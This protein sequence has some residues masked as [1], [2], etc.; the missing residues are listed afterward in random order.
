MHTSNLTGPSFARVARGVLAA[1]VLAV[2]LA[3]CAGD[4]ADGSR[5]EGTAPT[6][7]AATPA[8]PL[9]RYAGYTSSTHDD[10]THWVCRPEANDVCQGNLDTTVVKADGTMTVEPFRAAADPPVDCFYLYPT[11]SRDQTF[12]SDW[13]ASPDEEGWV[14]LN[15][16][17]RLRATC[18]LYAPIY[19]QMTL[20]GL[21]SRLGGA[22]STVPGPG[23]KVDPYADVLDAFRTYMAKDNR[24]RPFVL[25]GHSQGSSTLQRLVAEEIDPNPDVRELMLAAFLAGWPLGVPR[26]ADVGGAFKNIPLCR[27]PG[28]T[29]CVFA[30]SSYRSTAKPPADAYFGK[31]KGGGGVAAVGGGDVAA[32]NTPATLRDSEPADLHSYFPANRMESILAAPS[33]PGPPGPWVDP[34]KGAVTTPFVSVPG[35]V[36]GTCTTTDGFHYLSV[37]TRAVKADPRADDFGGELTPQWG[38]H[39]QD[40]NLV[41]GDVV[42]WVTGLAAHVGTR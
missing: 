9:A 8:G 14:T 39:L 42:E 23:E 24:G 10:P 20:S 40:V 16:A 26:G 31:V 28:Q 32:C 35:L 22:S 1:F 34:A 36:S 11:I 15:Q 6:P 27:R 4:D 19:R 3:G 21:G 37:E 5:P 17:A 2:G 12:N 7:A 30:W 29:G 18:R 41:M 13:S 25:V 33:A 38:L